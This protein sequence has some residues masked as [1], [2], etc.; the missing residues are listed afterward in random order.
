[1]TEIRTSA[2]IFYIDDNGKEAIQHIS[3]TDKS[4][5]IERAENMAKTREVTQLR[6]VVETFHEKEL[7]GYTTS[8]YDIKDGKLKPRSTS[9]G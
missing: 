3:G 7:F 6:I 8:W 2:D 9:W 1:M 5:Y 4:G